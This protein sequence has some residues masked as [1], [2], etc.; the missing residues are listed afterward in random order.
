MPWHWAEHGQVNGHLWDLQQALYCTYEGSTPLN[1][2]AVAK[3]FCRRPN[4]GTA[5]WYLLSLEHDVDALL[6][7]LLP[8]GLAIFCGVISESINRIL[9]HGHNEHNNRGRG[10]GVVRWRGRMRCEG[11]NGRPFTGRPVCKLNE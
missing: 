7:N 8:F 3:D 9:K 2:A 4:V 10:G 11:V 5:L 1:C 6:Q